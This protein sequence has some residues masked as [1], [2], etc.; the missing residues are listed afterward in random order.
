MAGS[1]LL[2]SPFPPSRPALSPWLGWGRGR[3]SCESCGR[4]KDKA[5]Q[6]LTGQRCYLGVCRAMTTGFILK[7]CLNLSFA[8][9]PREEGGTEVRPLPSSALCHLA[10]EDASMTV[11]ILLLQSTPNC[12]GSKS[13][14]PPSPQQPQGTHLKKLK[15]M[16]EYLSWISPQHAQ[17]K[18]DACNRQA[19]DQKQAR[20]IPW[21]PLRGPMPVVTGC[22]VAAKLQ[23]AH[24]CISVPSGGCSQA[25]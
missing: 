3:G 12:A 22:R 25:G 21:L 17:R 16:V 23:L 5:V 24:G 10:P 7:Y 4:S 11:G 14:S 19:Q 1:E 20:S 13:T 2:S 8:Y 9:L 18:W 6:A 15:S